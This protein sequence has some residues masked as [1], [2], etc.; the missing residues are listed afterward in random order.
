[1]DISTNE[2][3]AITADN[4]VALQTHMDKFDSFEAAA[5]DGM[6]LK[7]QMGK[8]YKFPESMDKLADDNVR[9]EFRAGA[10]KLLGRTIPKDLESFA[11]VN[12]KA[13]LADDAEV[14]DALIGVIKK[15]AVDEGVSTESVGKMT[16]LFNGPM[17]EYFAAK[18]ET[19]NTAADEKSKADHAIA[20]KACNDSLTAHAD[21]GT[22]EALDAKSV[23]L[24][25][26]LKNNCKLS[27]E[28]ANNVAEFLR[29]GEG[30]TNPV[31]RKLMIDTF[32][33]LATEGSTE[34]GQHGDTPP[35]A[36]TAAQQMPVTGKIL[37]W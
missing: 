25:T 14:D 26:A 21:F 10:N 7:S 23:K 30:A 28:D 32:A 15:W 24:H 12:F 2:H 27:P 9:S 3:A 8:P 34:N 29:D 4:R 1:M 11:D 22:V 18:G 33:P 20:V 5:L 16:A 19:M 6:D 36:K 13:G 37:G 17:G 35:A 31:L